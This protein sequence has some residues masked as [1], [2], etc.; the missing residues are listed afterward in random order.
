MTNDTPAPSEMSGHDLDGTIVGAISEHPSVDPDARTIKAEAD[1]HS[2][3]RSPIAGVQLGDR[4]ALNG[5]QYQIGS[6]TIVS[7]NGLGLVCLYV[8]PTPPGGTIAR[9]WVDREPYLLD[10]CNGNVYAHNPEDVRIHE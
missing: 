2:D 9:L 3:C 5:E 7:K 8:D 6:Q 10:V 4:L 1:P